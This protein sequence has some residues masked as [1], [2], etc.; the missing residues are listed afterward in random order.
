MAI[1]TR[2]KR[3]SALRHVVRNLLPL[4]DGSVNAGDRAMLAGLYGGVHDSEAG[5]GGG[6]SAYWPFYE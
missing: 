3:M 4:P 6:G 5:G 2:R 1:D